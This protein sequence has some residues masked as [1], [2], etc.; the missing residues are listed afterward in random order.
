MAY[1]EL[2]ISVRISGPDPI[3]GDRYIA[4]DI[5]A[6][7]A[8]LTPP[9]IRA[10]AGQQVFVES[11]QTLYILKGSTNADWEE[12]GAGGPITGDKYFE[13]IQA[14]ASIQWTI[15]HNLGKYPSVN[16]MDAS[17]NIVECQIQHSNNNTTILTFNVAIDGTAIFN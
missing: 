5:A 16:V 6:R 9:S 10:K 11:N 3:D 13:F 7:D 8:L 4:A 1:F 17:N 14:P 15:N 2:P 12:V